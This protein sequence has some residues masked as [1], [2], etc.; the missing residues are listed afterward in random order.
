MFPSTPSPGRL[1]IGGYGA[2]AAAGLVLQVDYREVSGL[3]EPVILSWS[4][5]KDAALAL[6][7]LNQDPAWQVVRLLT[8]VTGDYGRIS[9]HGVRRALLLRQATAVGL[10]LTEVVIPAGASNETYEA[11]MAA[12]LATPECAGV[13]WVAFGD[14]LL[15]DI[16]AYR[17]RQMAGL[18]RQAL[19]PLWGR[20]TAE[21]ARTFIEAGFRAVITTVDPSRLD[22][23]FAGREYD[24]DLLADLP[25]A[26]DPCGERGEFH[27]FAWDG[28]I[29]ARPVPVRRGR[30]VER[31][32]FV[33]CDLEPA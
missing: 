24:H 12:A 16:R 6:W 14:L 20:D 3:A 2:V 4:G 27:T 1:W 17:E 26:V 18:D 7:A 5:G 31:D 10:P 23:S 13:R 8:T 11:R 22:P 28:P 9:M 33:F 21:T 29:F 32:G 15:D 19:F 25:P 30:V